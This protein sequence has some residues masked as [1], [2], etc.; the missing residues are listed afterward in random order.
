MALSP[1]DQRWIDA[2]F[3]CN[4]NA[5]QATVDCGFQGSRKQAAQAGWHRLQ[6]AAVREEIDRRLIAW[7]A[8]HRPTV[9]Q[10]LDQLLDATRVDPIDYYD[11]N[12]NMKPLSEIPPAA[13]RQIAAIETEEHVINNDLVL[14]KKVKLWD[15][16]ASEKMYG[17]AKKLFTDK[18][19]HSGE[20]G[21]PL[22]VVFQM[23][24]TKGQGG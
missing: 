10:F 21:G 14:A 12:G 24:L 9:E 17:Q 4:G 8:L 22:R 20:G 3:A 15:R 5:T 23:D 16:R 6:K 1:V 2:Y 19:E 11:E 18:V 7:R 13:R